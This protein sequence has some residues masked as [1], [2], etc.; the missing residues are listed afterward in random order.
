MYGVSAQTIR[1]TLHQ[2]GLHGCRP[3]KEA[4]SKVDAQKSPQTAFGSDGVKHVWQQPGD[5]YKDQCVLPTVKHG[6][7]GVMVWAAWVLPALGS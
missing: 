3:R 2:I 4:S 5:E 7:G 1:H 6:G